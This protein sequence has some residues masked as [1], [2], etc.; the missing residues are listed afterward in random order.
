[1]KPSKVPPLLVI[2]SSGLI[3][4]AQEPQILDSTTHQE[5]NRTITI[6]HVCPLTLPAPTPIENEISSNLLS[7]GSAGGLIEPGQADFLTISANVYENGT[8]LRW[9]DRDSG[10][11]LEAFSGIDWKHFT[12]RQSVKVNE[13]RSISYLLVA[14]DVQGTSPAVPTKPESFGFT[15]LVGDKSYGSVRLMEDLHA[16]YEENCISLIDACEKG[17]EAQEKR[18]KELRENPP[19]LKDVTIQYRVIGTEEQN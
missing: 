18:Q 10:E 2:F 1:M 7:A 16:Y 3:L 11:R 17:K 5:G 15:M 9:T 13:L 19:A 6:E 8:H 12:G 4:H 14:S